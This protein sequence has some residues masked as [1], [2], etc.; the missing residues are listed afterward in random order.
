M[1][2]TELT[3]EMKKENAKQAQTR[4][5]LV[6]GR[7]VRY[8]KLYSPDR[9]AMG[10]L[11]DVEGRAWR[12]ERAT[13]K[14]DDKALKHLHTIEIAGTL[15]RVLGA[16]ASVVKATSPIATSKGLAVVMLETERGTRYLIVRDEQSDR[17][18]RS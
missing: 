7:P 10:L 1:K 15:Y 14:I 17:K 4:W 5:I 11:R 8:R 3:T 2:T 18:V 12:I 13:V 16:R 9:P 6:A